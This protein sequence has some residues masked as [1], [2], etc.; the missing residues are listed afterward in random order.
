MRPEWV[1][2]AN[3]TA[4]GGRALRVAGQVAK[5]LE[6]AGLQVRMEFT[7]KRG[8]APELARQALDRRADRIVVCGGDGTI[9]ELLPVLSGRPAPPLGIIPCGTCNDLAL[10]LGIPRRIESAVRVLLDGTTASVDLAKV[11]D[12]LFAT[13]AGCGFDAEVG[14]T[15]RTGWLSG[16]TGYLWAALQCLGRFRPPRMK[17]SGEFGT[18]EDNVLLVATGN[19]SSYGGGMRI[20]PDADPFDGKLDICIVRPV[21]GW[22][23]LHMLS[24]VFRG[25][26]ISHPAVQIERSS[27]VTI[28]GASSM[29]HQLFGD[30]ED[31]AT[32]PCTIKAEAG[33]IDVSLP[34]SEPCSRP[35]ASGT[36]NIATQRTFPPR[37]TP[38]PSKKALRAAFH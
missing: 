31:L 33:A 25:G 18:V 17:I 24:R 36:E 37:L 34:K 12:R 32:T 1:L 15:A 35:L 10:A 21:A 5:S 4:G 27:W 22:T 3:P 8:D 26:H 9:N 2:I 30:G 29:E 28:E 11:G 19:T 20:V 16:T 13:V 7:R 38:C 6:R 14:Q 23:A